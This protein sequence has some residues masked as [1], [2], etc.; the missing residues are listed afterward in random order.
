MAEQEHL[1]FIY[2]F[3]CCTVAPLDLI[4]DAFSL[5]RSD[6]IKQRLLLIENGGAQ[7]L[8]RAVDG[9][10][11]GEM[12][13]GVNWSS[14]SLETLLEISECLGSPVLA[15]ICRLL[16]EDYRHRCSG[17]PDLILWHP[18]WKRSR[19]VEVKSTND[20]LSDKQEVWLE[21]L[22]E[23]GVDV[24]VC[25]V[26]SAKRF[27]STTVFTPD[28]CVLAA[29]SAATSSSTDAASLA[30]V[31]KSLFP[32]HDDDDGEDDAA[33]SHVAMANG[34]SSSSSG[35]V[36]LPL[37]GHRFGCDGSSS[38]SSSSSSAAAAH[39]ACCD[40]LVADRTV[41][42]VREHTNVVDANAIQVL[43][44]LTQRHL[45]HLSRKIGIF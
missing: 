45:G 26:D 10:H 22:A 42:V 4:T 23:H 18:A 13:V 34:S 27:E 28:T 12:C 17:M 7:D 29:T 20:R 40:L 31:L 36:E 19:F 39:H 15:C 5:T 24:Q 30:R 3:Y 44:E 38:S 2:F 25:H 37:V 14:Y 43:D 32:A 11:R 6:Q 1:L 35:S 41:V 33:T 9:A 21:A 16:A 8:L